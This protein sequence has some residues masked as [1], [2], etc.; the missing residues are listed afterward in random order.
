[1]DARQPAVYILASAR[2][3]TLY[4]GVTSDLVKRIW[5][6]RNDCVPGFTEHHGVHTMVFYE[7]HASME[8]A[9]VREKRLKKWEHWIPAVAGMTFSRGCRSRAGMALDVVIP[10]KA[11][12][13]ALPSLHPGKVAAAS[14][15][16]F[17]TFASPT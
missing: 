2:N 1:M 17:S 16:S 15:H 13:Q 7:L 14:T 3:G 10:A 8:S 9:I 12:I 5:Q 6:H 4:I 11:G